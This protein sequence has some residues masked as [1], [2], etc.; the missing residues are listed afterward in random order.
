M[1]W[2]KS[3]RPAI[4]W[5]IIIIL[6]TG[7]PGY[8]FPAVSPF[9][10]RISLDKIVH[11]FIFAVFVVTLLYGIA[12]QQNTTPNL[13]NSILA[14]L[15]GILVGAGTELMQEYLFTGRSMSL[16]DF[17]A[18]GIGSIGGTLIFRKWE[19]KILSL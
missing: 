9:A 6:L 15:I 16:W 2:T 18:D 10:D 4:I 8:L 19:K 17:V 14:I 5:L 3:Y 11:F 1:K 7:L 13:H 12:K